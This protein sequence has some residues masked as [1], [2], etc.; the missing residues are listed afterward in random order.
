MNPNLLYLGFEKNCFMP[1]NC[2]KLRSD[3]MNIENLL[4]WRVVKYYLLNAGGCIE[5]VSGTVAVTRQSVNQLYQLLAPEVCSMLHDVDKS[6]FV[7]PL[8]NPSRSF[9]QTFHQDISERRAAN[10]P[11]RTTGTIRAAAHNT[12]C[13]RVVVQKHCLLDNVDIR[14]DLNTVSITITL[15]S[16]EGYRNRPVPGGGSYN[17]FIP[18][19][20]VRE[21][22]SPSSTLERKKDRSR[23]KSPFRSF[24]WKK[25]GGA[26]KSPGSRSAGTAHSDDEDTVLR[27]LCEDVVFELA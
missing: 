2:I 7:C 22:P 16:V 6:G 10:L 11:R 3:F 19:R 24:R 4:I 25:S 17:Y 14:E 21:S 26:P 15:R 20:G 18:K 27:T 8:P 13:L 5:S 12:N 9:S 1:R 23:S